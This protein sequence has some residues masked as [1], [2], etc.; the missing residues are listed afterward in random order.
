MKCLLFRKRE[1]SVISVNWNMLVYSACFEESL[2]SYNYCF[3]IYIS[4]EL[5]MIF[6][7]KYFY[8]GQVSIVIFLRNLI[9]NNL[10]IP[11]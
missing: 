6:T 4:S 3:F 2:L 1:A 5:I 10:F 8:Y 7:I 9:K 11:I